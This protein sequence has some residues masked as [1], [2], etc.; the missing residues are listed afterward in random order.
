MK[1][2]FYALIILLSLSLN[3]WAVIGNGAVWEYRTTATNTNVNGGAFDATLAGAGTDYTLQDAAQISL[4]D[5]SCTQNSVTVNSAAGLFT[6]QMV[7]NAM[8]MASGTNIV[9]GFYFMTTYI[10]GKIAKFD[11]TMATAGN[12][13]SGVGKLGGAL[14]LPT[15]AIMEVAVSGNI[16]WIKAGTYTLTGAISIGT[17]IGAQTNPIQFVGYNTTRGD[18]P[19]GADRPTIACGANQVVLGSYFSVRNLIFTGSKASSSL[20]RSGI[21]TTLINDSINNTNATSA[22]GLEANTFSNISA[23]ELRSASG[24]ALTLADGVN[25]F[26]TYIHDSTIGASGAANATPKF[27]GCAFDTNGTGYIQTAASRSGGFFVGNVF[28]KST[29]SHIESTAGALKNT[30]VQGNVFET[31]ADAIKDSVATNSGFS[32]YQNIFNGNTRNATNI[33]TLNSTNIIADPL[34]NNPDSGDF[35]VKTG[36]PALDAGYKYSNSGLTGS[37]K[38]NIGIDQDDLA[39]GGTRSWAY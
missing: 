1:K 24:T 5:V 23:C 12:G 39:T 17:G 3:A 28:Y 8:Q 31:S 19:T 15:D 27:Y 29:G 7:G 16:S 20:V 30:L 14:Y 37:Y 38:V 32:V 6:A 25:V 9:P 35:T 18:M 10:S 33:G 22:T 21:G 13:S 34:L 11:R 36:S 2:L 26:Y 4:T